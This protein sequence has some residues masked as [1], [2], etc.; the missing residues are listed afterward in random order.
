MT[1]ARRSHGLIPM[2]RSS[3]RGRRPSRAR[4]PGLVVE[5][6]E[7]RMLLS[8]ALV[9]LNAA[10]T[11]AG[12]SVS[13]F[14]TTTVGTLNSG[15][16][17]QSLQSNL[18]ADGTKL[19]FASEATD[20]VGGLD[21]TNHASDVFVR[22]L[23]TGQTTLVSATPS[24]QVGNGASFDPAISPD[25][26]Y[27]A[28]LSD[29]TNLSTV[30]ASPADV[31]DVV[32]G[33]DNQT[34]AYLYVRDLA[35]GTTTLMDQTPVGVGSDGFC[36]GQFVFS[37]NSQ[38]LAFIDTSDNLTDAPVDPNNPA[39]GS[40]SGLSDAGSQPNYV[41]VRDLAAQTTSLVSVS[42]GGMASA[43]VPND[44]EWQGELVFSPDSQSL[45]FDSTAT[46]LTDD[47]ANNAP[48]PDPG[49]AYQATNLFL[50]NLSTGTTT[51][52]SVTTDGQLAEG[53]SGGAILG[54][55][56]G[57]AVFSPNG[58]E[59][60]F[61][62]TATDLT[63]NAPDTSSGGSADADPLGNTNVFVR[64]LA[65]G[66]TTL[67]SATP[68]GL[69]S[70]GYATDPIFSPDGQSVAYVSNATDLTSNPQDP[71]LP[72]V[73]TTTTGSA[74]SGTGDSPS[75][76]GLP[77]TTTTTT[78]GPLPSILGLL[79]DTTT[80]SAGPLPFLNFNV[81]LTNLT[82]GTTSLVSVT[83]QGQL[84][85]GMALNLAFSPDGRYLAFTSSA[86][87]LTSN[88]IEATPPSTP[89]A[90][91]N[92]SGSGSAAYGSGSAARGSG[93]AAR[94]SGS[95]S[96]SY[97]ATGPS[98]VFVRDLQTGTT[99]LTSVTTGGLLPSANSGGL[100]F[101]SDSGSLYF[102]SS[103]IDLTSNPPDTSAAQSSSFGGVPHNLFDFDLATGTTSL[104]SATPEGQ[105]SDGS[106][107]NAV[108][109]PDGQTLDFATNANDLVP[110]GTTSPLPNIYA[111]SGPYTTP[112][113]FSF[114]SWETSADESAGQAVVKV[115]LSNPMT[116]AAS[117]DYA[118]QP[119]TA[120]AGTDYKATSGTLDFAPGQTSATFTVPLAAGD[121]FTG[122][123]SA[124]L[125][126]SNPQGGSLGYPSATL[127]LTSTLAVPTPTPTTPTSTPTTPISTPTTPTS[128]PT[129]PTGTPAT[130]TSTLPT[131]PTP[132]STPKTPTSTP[133][134][135]TPTV[136]APATPAEPGPTVVSVAPMKGRRGITTLVIT[137]NK[138]L[139]PATAQDAANYQVSLPGRTI[140]GSRGHRST[141]S[142]SRS[143]G[144]TAAAYNS[145]THQVTLTLRTKSAPGT[146]DPARDQRGFRRSGEYGW[147]PAE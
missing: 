58:Q 131:S 88:P 97:G 66:T 129:T 144:V 33:A 32:T 140:H 54:A 141:T 30:P 99:T 40:P 124:Q 34:A 68:G 79:T 41:Y 31:A 82:T 119:G 65:T 69:M 27:V 28:F 35:T 109:S 80:A 75:N 38:Y 122:T 104:I 26:Q 105:L 64:D 103:A 43:N 29:A 147:S 133:T 55:N 143:V 20:L 59:V 11:A 9:T 121:Q 110:G 17:S 132:T 42:T 14:D 142:P 44:V 92:S 134:T 71:N 39:P 86:V 6:C 145:Q 25:G 72:S 22:D 78:T 1:F 77:T 113:Q 7:V 10:G 73:S 137:F 98:N 13:G 50:R 48:N 21:D 120:Q 56:S 63:D 61:V 126:L 19:V 128:T 118:V 5:G 116:S 108:L 117:V 53:N 2:S 85:D 45:V 125:V 123:R 136:T 8:T 62:S 96:L 60:A 67:V 23:A 115:Q 76:L 37:P 100:I 101:S 112:G 127:N 93:S 52:L 70:D 83:P 49:S 135:P 87:D 74:P 139:A 89:G 84:S 138:P 90:S 106:N 102:A 12:N 47:L 36:T 51:L 16:P 81:F 114:Q 146:D 46:D 18:S 3:R 57:F 130:P 94:G 91:S 111:A 4:G 24:G 107:I 15:S 95:P